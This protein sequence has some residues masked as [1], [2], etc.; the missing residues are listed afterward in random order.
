MRKAAQQRRK[1]SSLKSRR[2]VV[3]VGSSVLT[4]PEESGVNRR[5]L[6]R[7]VSQ[8]TALSSSRREVV[9][10][11][12][13]A[14]AA[15]LKRLGMKAMPS[16]IPERQAAA[17]VG[18]PILMEAYSRAFK[19]RGLD[20]AQVLLTHAD[21][22]ARGR[23]LNACNTFETLLS[24]KVVPIV[25][26]NDTVSI[27][28]LRFGDNDILA[29]QV[30]QMIRAELVVILSDVEG[31]YDADPR[32]SPDA[33]MLSRVEGLPSGVMKAAGQ[34]VNPLAHGG[35]AAKMNAVKVL[36]RVG[37]STLIVRGRTPGIIKR[38]LEGE[39]LGT[40]FI[41]NGSRLKGKKGWI[42]T[43]ASPKGWL[44]LDDGAVRAL[45]ER[46][47]SLLPS[48]VAEVGGDFRF[49]DL[50]DIRDLKGKSLGRG[51]IN[52]DAAQMRQIAG[53]QTSEISAILGGKEFD[54]V[55]HR[56]NLALID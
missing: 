27:E 11:S 3:K 26:E 33:Q 52:Y 37:I 25:N 48:G 46:G 31:L 9:L 6:G 53:K 2:I 54:E 19:R 23:F 47:K 39:V 41:P 17:A 10:V 36:N 8:V 51:L 14:I 13:G 43:T 56:N 30:A 42:G 38:A 22:D 20:M 29:A 32:I 50:V 5:V 4:S 12:S 24:R 28:E 45:V 18:Q 15:G 40:L 16:G 21:L 7:I 35:M 1:D 49:G 44:R 55:I 34:S